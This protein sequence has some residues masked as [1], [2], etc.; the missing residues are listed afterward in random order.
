MNR[1]PTSVGIADRGEGT[2]FVDDEERTK[3]FELFRWYRLGAGL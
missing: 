2:A 1:T 3:F